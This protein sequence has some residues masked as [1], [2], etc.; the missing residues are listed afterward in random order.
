MGTHVLDM[1]IPSYVSVSDLAKNS[2]LI[3]HSVVE[4][5]ENPFVGQDVGREELGGD[6]ISS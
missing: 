1:G 6:R 4:P 5:I 2:A 3:F